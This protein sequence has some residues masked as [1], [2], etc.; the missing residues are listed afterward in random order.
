MQARPFLARTRLFFEEAAAVKQVRQRERSCAGDPLSHPSPQ[1]PIRNRRAFTLIELLLVIAIVALLI[2]LLLP[3]LSKGKKA[4]RVT[5]CESNMRQFGGAMAAYAADFK[6]AMGSFS[7][8]PNANHSTFPDLNAAYNYQVAH[9]NQA[10]DIARRRTGHGADGYY[11]SFDTRIV[12]R[13]FNHLPLIDGGYYNER[14]PEPTT[15][16]PEDRATILW[17]RSYLDPAAGLAE[18][19]DPDPF[20][21]PG[22]KKLL[23][24]W[25]TYQLV[26][27]A[28]TPDT[29]QGVMSQADGAPGYHFLY[30]DSN[31]A[32]YGFGGRRFDEVAFPSQKVCQF[33]LFDR[34][35]YKRDLWYAY[36]AATQPLLMFDASVALRST[37][38][39]NPGWRPTTP[40]SVFPLT[41]HYWPVG[42]DPPTL[43]GAQSDVVTGYYRWTRM[44]L[45]G[46][47][48]GA[49]EVWR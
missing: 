41:Y 15:A 13:N 39:S 36:P 10:V 5:I 34:H 14:L 43:S 40:N 9:A 17:Q 12:D 47:D 29:G 49:G 32:Y 11:T 37:R 4:A 7:W 1:S 25:N 27:V 30:D 18:T 42:S 19:G 21:P 33:D 20:S 16:C 2:G 8:R 35:C 23:P 44:G 22:F 28:W 45:K 46:V 6:S 3:A 24:F 38:D 48:Y 26:P 31:A